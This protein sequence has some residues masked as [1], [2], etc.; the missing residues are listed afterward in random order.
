MEKVKAIWNDTIIAESDKA[1]FFDRRYYF[2]PKDVNKEFLKEIDYTTGCPWKGTAHYYDVVVEGK[3]N[4][5]AAWYYPNPKEKAQAIKDYVSFWHGVEI[6]VPK[7]YS[8]PNK[9]AWYKN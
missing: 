5:R 7:N 8:P 9:Q 4:I 1:L 2:P 3:K 6:K